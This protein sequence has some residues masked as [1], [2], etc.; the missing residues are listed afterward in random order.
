MDQAELDNNYKKDITCHLTHSVDI[1]YGMVLSRSGSET[2]RKKVSLRP[3]LKVQVLDGSN[4]ALQAMAEITS[5][6]SN[7][8][9]IEKM[10][11]PFAFQVFG[12]KM[13]N[14]LRL[15]E[16]WNTSVEAYN[17]CSSSLGLQDPY[18]MAM[19]NL[20]FLP[21]CLS[22]TCWETKSLE[23]VTSSKVFLVTMTFPL[24]ELKSRA[25]FQ[26]MLHVFKQKV[27]IGL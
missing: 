1:A 8:N 23:K 6:Q 22:Q 17:R 18:L 16:S 24:Q 3:L 10:R 14:G 2:V 12:N 11:V 5:C 7:P 13:L 4:V 25:L 26:I 19:L 9:N 21:P 27:M 15:Y 20:V